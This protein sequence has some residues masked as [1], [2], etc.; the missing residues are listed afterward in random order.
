[1]RASD[2]KRDALGVVDRASH[3]LFADL[4]WCGQTTFGDEPIPSWWRSN[5][6][7]E[8]VTRQ[9]SRTASVANSTAGSKLFAYYRVGPQRPSLF[10]FE[11]RELVH[12]GDEPSMPGVAVSR[13]WPL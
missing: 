6:C 13:S 12:R 4:C 9:R 2:D 5:L 3:R 8:K 1:M 7:I 10:D 11:G